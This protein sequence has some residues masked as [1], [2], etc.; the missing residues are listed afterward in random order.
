MKKYVSL[1]IVVLFL[2]SCSNAPT[3]V[4]PV[5]E[6]IQV[7]QTPEAEEK[8]IMI[9]NGEWLPY[10]SENLPHYGAG[11]RIVTEAFALEGIKVEWG[12][13]PWSRAYSYAVDGTWEASIGWIKTPER[14]EEVYFS[15]PVYGGPWV[16]FHLKSVPFEWNTIDDL[17]GLTIGATADYSYGDEFDN[18][19]KQGIINVDRVPTEVQNFE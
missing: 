18:A 1:M 14:E 9:T 15:E 16:F 17:Q 12:F 19:E 10:H 13:F 7:E 5:V 3:Q 8:T 4:E 6:E 11:S 2:A